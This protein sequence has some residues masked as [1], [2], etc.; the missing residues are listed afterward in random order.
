MGPKDPEARYMAASAKICFPFNAT[1]RRTRFKLEQVVTLRKTC[2]DELCESRKVVP[3]AVSTTGRAI[4]CMF[5]TTVSLGPKRPLKAACLL[6][7][8]RELYNCTN[9]KG[10]ACTTL[11]IGSYVENV[12][13]R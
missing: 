4:R 1:L 11:N 9:M 6:H 7:P 13:Y 3:S 8:P 5:I 10:V 2:L 12:R